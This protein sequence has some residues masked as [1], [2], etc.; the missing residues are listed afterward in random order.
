MK[1]FQDTTNLIIGIKLSLRSTQGKRR[2]GSGAWENI[3]L[4]A[5]K[6][7]FCQV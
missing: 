1:G 2:V 6:Y 5:M 4:G 7:P 3:L